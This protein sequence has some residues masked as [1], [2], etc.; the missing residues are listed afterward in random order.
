MDILG[1]K[2]LLKNVSI[3]DCNVI[4]KV[5]YELPTFG[6][7]GI[8]PTQLVS[9]VDT[10]HVLVLQQNCL[11]TADGIASVVLLLPEN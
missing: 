7:S 8:V 10:S 11:R 5:K 4:K 3:G 1:T 9:S 2:A 6:S